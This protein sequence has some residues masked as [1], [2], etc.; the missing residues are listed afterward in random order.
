LIF[1]LIMLRDNIDDETNNRLV[2]TKIKLL[3][4]CLCTS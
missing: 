4:H 1:E 3:L 2:K